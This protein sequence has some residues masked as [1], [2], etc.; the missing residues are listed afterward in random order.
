MHIIYFDKRLCS[1]FNHY[2]ISIPLTFRE[3]LLILKGEAL[4]PLNQIGIIVLSG[5]QNFI[6]DKTFTLQQQNAVVT[7]V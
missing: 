4:F 2:L 3:D 1:A 5:D 6:P 7:I